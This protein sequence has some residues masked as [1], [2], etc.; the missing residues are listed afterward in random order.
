MQIKEEENK[1]TCDND[2]K[3]KKKKGNDF[4]PI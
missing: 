1:N 2:S 4:Y 3:I